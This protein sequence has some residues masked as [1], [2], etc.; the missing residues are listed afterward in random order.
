[1]RRPSYTD[2]GRRL[3]FVRLGTARQGRGRVDGP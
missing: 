1:M 3:R 2:F